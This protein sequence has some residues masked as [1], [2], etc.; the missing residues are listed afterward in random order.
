MEEGDLGENDDEEYGM[1][2]GDDEY[3]S[4]EDLEEEVT[5]K[6][7]LPTLPLPPGSNLRKRY[8]PI[9]DQVT[10][11]LMQDGKL[12][13]AQRVCWSFMNGLLLSSIQKQQL[14]VCPV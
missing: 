13:V 11:L 4:E 6:F 3:G 8:E 14:T 2:G 5:H 1:E 12:S 10:K 7:G 9:V